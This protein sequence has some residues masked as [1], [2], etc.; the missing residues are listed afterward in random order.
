MTKSI[1][2]HPKASL[3]SELNDDL[4]LTAARSNYLKFGASQEKFTEVVISEVDR[5]TFSRAVRCV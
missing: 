2:I 4:S 3:S 5:D 1:Q